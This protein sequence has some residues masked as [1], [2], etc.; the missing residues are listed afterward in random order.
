[1]NN[2][3]EEALKENGVKGTKEKVGEILGERPEYLHQ[4]LKVGRHEEEIPED[5]RGWTWKDAGVRAQKLNYLVTHDI[6]EVTY[7]SGN[8]T[9]YRAKNPDELREALTEYLVQEKEEEIEIRQD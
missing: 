5:D 6:L 8:K 3:I 1:M 9:R 7:D 4:L 2:Q